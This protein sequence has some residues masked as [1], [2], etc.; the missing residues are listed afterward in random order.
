MSLKSQWRNGPIESIICSPPHG[1]PV[2]SLAVGKTNFV[3]GSADHG[4][5]E[6]NLYE[7]QYVGILVNTYVNYT[8]KN[9]G[10]NN[11]LVL[12][13]ILPLEKLLVELWIQSYVFGRVK[14]LNVIISLV[15]SIF[16]IIKGKY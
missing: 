4:L 12:A 7:Y 8:T 3:T 5:R 1:Q 15:I 9:M 10:I 13:A 11:G 16:V 2:F 14:Q 6:Y